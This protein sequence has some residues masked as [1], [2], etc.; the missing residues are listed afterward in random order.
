MPAWLILVYQPWLQNVEV[1]V[2]PVQV[3]YLHLIVASC[4]YCH[5]HEAM[6]FLAPCLSQVGWHNVYQCLNDEDMCTVLT[7]QVEGEGRHKLSWIWMAPGSGSSSSPEHVQDGESSQLRLEVLILTIT[8][9]STSPGVAE[10][11]C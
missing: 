10:C 5:A 8:S 2:G 11:M 7:N 6:V 4:T 3:A 1:H 9:L